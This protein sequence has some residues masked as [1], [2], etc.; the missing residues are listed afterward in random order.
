MSNAHENAIV[1]AAVFAVV[2]GLRRKLLALASV[3]LYAAAFPPWNWPTWGFCFTPLAPLWM[4]V[5]ERRAWRDIVEAVLIGFAMGWVTTGFVR[6][7][8]VARSQILD[9][10]CCLLFGLQ[11]AIWP[12]SLRWMGN[13]PVLM[14]GGFL[15]AAGTLAEWLQSHLFNGLIWSMTSLSLPVA[16]APLAQWAT[17]VTPFGVSA[18][19]YLVNFLWFP[20]RSPIG[21]RRWRGPVLAGGLLSAAWIGGTQI[22]SAVRVEPLKF[23]ALLAQPHL[24]GEKGKSWQPWVTLDRLTRES[25]TETGP[26][27][28]IVWPETSL[29][30]SLHPEQGGRQE[31]LPSGCADAPLSLKRFQQNSQPAYGTA[32][33]VGVPLINEVI[34]KKYGLEVTAQ[35]RINAACLV[36]EN[37]ISCHEKLA[38]VPFK[39]GLPI[40]L[41][42]PWV[43]NN[44]MTYFGLSAPLTPGKQFRLLTFSTRDGREVSLAVSICFES[45]L[46]WLPQYDRVN[47]AD[48]IV[49]LMYDGD[50][51]NYSEWTERQLLAC[52]CRA[53][54]SRTWNL[55]CSTWDGSVIIDPRGKIVGRL[56]AVSGV[57]RT[58]ARNALLGR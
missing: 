31:N 12:L 19:L 34:V 14:A 39:E 51:T 8:A 36:D 10:A 32:C 50:F 33:L 17:Y 3:G 54:E 30:L 48:A 5:S 58:D 28:L 35:Q 16:G 24:R 42:T 11:M 25:L 23:S 40:A 21:W 37:R 22:E 6:D 49:H 15:A 1:L 44:L 18:F 13:R 20:E 52:R 55:V 56:P 4:S 27:D 57:L 45:H 26:V 53:I 46:P 29:A 47:K 7:A 2:G 9:A 38:L 41:D 43:R